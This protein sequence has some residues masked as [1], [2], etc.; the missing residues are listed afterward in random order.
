MTMFIKPNGAWLLLLSILMVFGHVCSFRR[1][2]EAAKPT[3][4]GQEVQE[5]R[6]HLTFTGKELLRLLQFFQR[7][8]LVAVTSSDWFGCFFYVTKS[9]HGGPTSM[10]TCGR[11]SNTRYAFSPFNTLSHQ[12]RP[13][14]STTMEL[15]NNAAPTFLPYLLDSFSFTMIIIVAIRIFLAS[16][17]HLLQ[18]NSILGHNPPWR[19]GFLALL[20]RDEALQTCSF[21]AGATR[22]RATHLDDK[23]VWKIVHDH[24]SLPQEAVAEIFKDREPIGRGRGVQLFRK[25]IVFRFNCFEFHLISSSMDLRFKRFKWLGYQVIRDSIGVAYK[26]F[27][28]Q[29]I[30]GLIVLRVSWFEIQALWN[31]NAV[32]LES[33]LLCDSS[34][35]RFQWLRSKCSPQRSWPDWRCALQTAAP[36]RGRCVAICWHRLLFWL[37]R[38]TTRNANSKASGWPRFTSS[39]PPYFFFGRLVKTATCSPKDIWRRHAFSFD[40]PSIEETY[41]HASE[42]VPTRVRRPTCDWGGPAGI[43]V[44]SSNDEIRFGNAKRYP[45]I[46]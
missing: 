5:P 38:F 17:T 23:H 10:M 3:F 28:C 8:L 11:L 27:G 33:Q 34:G 39:G 7:S 19:C 25:S 45:T 16:P 46:V 1:G 22:R 37:W 15:N 29:L 41:A 42:V 4:L 43:L 30:S 13:L 35:V 36:W 9:C 26:R 12:L 2:Q 6:R 32:G 20:Q 14:R 31:S 21:P 18:T 44:P 40:V 24:I